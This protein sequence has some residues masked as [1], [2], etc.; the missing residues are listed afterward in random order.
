MHQQPRATEHPLALNRASRSGQ[1][2]GVSGCTVSFMEATS[3]LG[4]LFVVVQPA[5]D[6]CERIEPLAASHQGAASYFEEN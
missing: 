6:G 2:S 3:L 5:R 4:Q 1:R